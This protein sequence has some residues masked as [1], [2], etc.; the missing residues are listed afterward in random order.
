MKLFTADTHF[1]R[2]GTFNFERG[3]KGRAEMS[4]AFV[5]NINAFTKPG[6]ILYIVGDYT[7]HDDAMY[8]RKQLKCKDIRVVVGNHDVDI[9]KLRA[10]FGENNVEH[11][12]FTK[13]R[14]VA[15]VLDHY[16]GA[17]WNASHYGAFQL[18]G[19]THDRREGTL[20]WIWPDRRAMDVG[21]DSAMR[22]FG[23]WRP[24]TEDEVY[25][26][27]APKAG[28]DPVQWYVDNYGRKED[29]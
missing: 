21:M 18:Y 23:E 4:A 11:R 12:M 28:H 6:D 25:E 7:H 15:T 29:N 17:Y 19:H 2:T 22:L 13:V 26:L 1:C 27:L 10:V 14:G 20:N 8:W 9:K 3:F 24:F 16:A 5:E